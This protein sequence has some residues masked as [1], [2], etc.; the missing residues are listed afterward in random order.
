MKGR[1]LTRLLL[2]LMVVFGV[3]ATATALLS[4][5]EIAQA[6]ENE[7]KA[8]AL[9]LARSIADG[10]TDLLLERSAGNIQAAIDQHQEM[11]DLS[12]IAVVDS[13]GDVV[14]HTFTPGVPDT[15]RGLMAAMRPGEN[16]SLK[17]E[18]R[19][20]A[21]EDGAEVIH[22]VQPVLGGR[23]GFV[24]IGMST[25]PI[26]DASAI[27]R[28]HL[29]TLAVFMVCLAVAFLFIRNIAAKLASLA[30]Y[31]Q[32]VAAHDFSSDCEVRSGDEIGA[33]AE[34][35]RGMARQI[36]GH[37][38]QLEQSVAEATRELKDALARFR[39]LWAISAMACW[40]R[41]RGAS[42]D[43]MPRCCASS[44]WRTPI[45]AAGSAKRCSARASAVWPRRP[46]RPKPPAKRTQ[47]LPG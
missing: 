7:Y 39:P 46:R 37:E 28:Q 21:L 15:V 9:A 25:A 36:A 31:A 26:K 22:V 24:H 47:P 44:G 35:M 5:R 41:A 20:L 13:Q 3:M 40:W 29:L 14:A 4:S 23:A 12:Y 38:T 18:I 16:G 6:L 33:L 11:G 42:S 10:N 2:F 8:R 17:P 43:T 34:A 1:L 19:T 32:R 45:I 27:L 30:A